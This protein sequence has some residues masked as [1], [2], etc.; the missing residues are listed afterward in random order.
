MRKPTKISVQQNSRICLLSSFVKLI[1]V[2]IAQKLVFRRTVQ[3]VKSNYPIH[4]KIATEIWSI[5]ASPII[6]LT[7]LTLYIKVIQIESNA[8]LKKSNYLIFFYLRNKTFDFALIKL[9]LSTLST[10]PTILFSSTFLLSTHSTTQ[11]IFFF[12]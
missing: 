10:S 12:G 2:I 6:K 4:L 5:P 3:P 1:K 7:I 8:D 11:H 9:H